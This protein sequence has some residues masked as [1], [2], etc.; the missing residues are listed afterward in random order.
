MMVLMR[1]DADLCRAANVQSGS[2]A[3]NTQSAYIC[4]QRRWLKWMLRFVEFGAVLMSENRDGTAELQR[5]QRLGAQVRD[6]IREDVL[7]RW[8]TATDEHKSHSKWVT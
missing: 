8:I 1:N 7:Q 5:R 2:F 3:R 6:M 4:C